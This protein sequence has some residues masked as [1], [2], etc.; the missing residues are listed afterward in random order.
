MAICCL[1]AA[2]TKE[3]IQKSAPGA[4]GPMGLFKGRGNNVEENTAKQECETSQ[5]PYSEA[6][7]STHERTS[8]SPLV[9]AV[10]CLLVMSHRSE[11]TAR[12]NP[13]PN[14]RPFMRI[15]FIPPCDR[16]PL[17]TLPPP[18]RQA[19]QPRGGEGQI[20]RVTH[21]ERKIPLHNKLYY[22][23]VY[24]YNLPSLLATGLR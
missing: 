23:D 21:G 12:P 2:G 20:S 16:G 19:R 1:A 3:R 14:K 9:R 4:Y 18:S 15:L 6:C 8:L 10:S 5:L 7:N 22:C 11:P 13:D 24:M 17:F